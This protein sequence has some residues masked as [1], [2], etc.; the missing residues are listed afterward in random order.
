MKSTIDTESA[1]G[2]LIIASFFDKEGF[3]MYAISSYQ[4]AVLTEPAVTDYKD[5]RN[6]YFNN[7][8]IIFE[9]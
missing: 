8:N 1:L 2:K 9:E 6:I 3:P 5:V 4:D 7:N